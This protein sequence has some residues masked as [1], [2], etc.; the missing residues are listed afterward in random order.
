M[1]NNMKRYKAQC[2]NKMNS[3]LLHENDKTLIRQYNYHA[4][5]TFLHY[6]PPPPRF[7][8]L[9]PFNFAFFPFNISKSFYFFLGGGGGFIDIILPL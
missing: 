4:N 5:D 6:P 8:S 3:C 9:S 7:F 1:L 2:S